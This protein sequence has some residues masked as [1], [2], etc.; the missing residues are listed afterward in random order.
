MNEVCS[1]GVLAVRSVAAS[2]SSLD[3]ETAAVEL[4]TGRL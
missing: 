4:R 2:A 1:C 3:L